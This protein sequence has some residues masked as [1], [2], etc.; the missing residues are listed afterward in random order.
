MKDENTWD[1]TDCNIGHPCQ[2][3]DNICTFRLVKGADEKENKNERTI[4]EHE[5]TK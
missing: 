3:C 1:Y 5:G 2:H 4:E